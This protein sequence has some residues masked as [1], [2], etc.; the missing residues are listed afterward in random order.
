MLDTAEAT[1]KFCTSCGAS[2][3][4][5]ICPRCSGDASEAAPPATGGH[6]GPGLVRRS[7][8]AAL[9]VIGLL[10]GA[11]G[12]V[13]L[14]STVDQLS[15]GLAA[16]RAELD[17]QERDIDA[18]MT[19]LGSDLGAVS[20][21]Q[22]RGASELDA[23]AAQ[24]S[25][26]PDAAAIARRT[27]PSVVVVQTESGLGSGFVVEVEAGTSLAVTN[28]HVIADVWNAGSRDV[29]VLRGDGTFPGH[30]R[31]AWPADDL[32]L[33]EVDVAM[34]TLQ[35]RPNRPDVGE[36]VLA[37]GAPLGL[38]GSI[39]SG[40]VSAFRTEGGVDYMQFDAPI[41]PGNS[42]G[43]IVDAEGSVV[44]VA[45]LKFVGNGAEGLGFAIP[46]DVLCRRIDVC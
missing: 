37:V 38:A 7:W 16:A 17:Q 2:T 15:D 24:V 28:F 36:P 20:A 31:D 22:E 18:R 45:V 32:A 10:A 42:G 21:A 27:Q 35:I 8:V 41:S 33:V 23:I 26:L 29:E 1:T 5:G 40:V 19:E 13:H 9:L 44:G 4:G 14:S 43:P 12:Y 11:V 46:T 39:T 34:P 3:H 30:I 6:S 25:G